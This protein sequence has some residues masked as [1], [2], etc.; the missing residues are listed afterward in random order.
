MKGEAAVLSARA[1]RCQSH[2]FSTT[3]RMSIGKKRFKFCISEDYYIISGYH[4]ESVFFVHCL[5]EK[6][7]RQFLVTV[8]FSVALNFTFNSCNIIRYLYHNA[9]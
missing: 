7:K 1:Q 6:Y 3:P 8:Y 2:Y 9:Q 4:H 5:D